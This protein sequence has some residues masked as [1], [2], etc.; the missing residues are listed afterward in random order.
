MM[1]VSKVIEEGRCACAS[2]L[3]SLYLPMSSV[4]PSEQG[5]QSRHR[6][7]RSRRTEL[8]PPNCFIRLFRRGKSDSDKIR[9]VTFDVDVIGRPAYW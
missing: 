8:F 3:A 7:C 1:I 9:R 4:T 5:A 6:V 2:P